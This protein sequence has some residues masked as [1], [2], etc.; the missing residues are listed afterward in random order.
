MTPPFTAP[1]F[2]DVFARYNLAVWPAQIVLLL[3]AVA[4][5]GIALLGSRAESRWTGGLL[6]LLWAWMGVV[7]HWGF[8]VEINP[9]AAVFGAAFV[10][11]AALLVVEGPVRENLAF[12]TRGGVG[13]IVGGL[14]IAW[15]LFLYPLAAILAGHGYPRMP[16]F[17][18]PCPT[19][20]YTFG[21]FLWAA[22]RVPW[23]VV[24]VPA[25]WSVIG[26]SAAF[27]LGI[28]EDAGLLLAGAVGTLFVAVRNRRIAR[29]SR[30]A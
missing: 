9:A 1:E 22:N 13:G 20:I 26:G 19:T 2:L 11:E 23:R 3:V 18:L 28:P 14:L 6:A 10:A 16:T 12:Q 21:M 24:V 25:A 29:E 27:S 8:F 5:A 4:A 15:A 7:Y 30:G 17:G